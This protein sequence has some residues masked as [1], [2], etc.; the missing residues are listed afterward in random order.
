MRLPGITDRTAIV[1]G[2]GSGKSTFGAWLLS[3]QPWDKQPYVC[4]DFKGEDLLMSIDGII[5]ID[6]REKLPKHPGL[7]ITHPLPRERDEVEDFMW[8]C[9]HR[10]NIGLFFDEG[11]L[12]P[13][14][15]PRYEA[16]RTLCVTGRSKRIPLIV[17]TQQPVR[18][19]RHVFTEATRIVC[20]RLN[21]TEDERR[22]ASYVR[23]LRDEEFAVLPRYYAY[24]YDTQEQQLALLQPVP[25]AD[26]ILATFRERLKPDRSFSWR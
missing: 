2:S 10:E 6:I 25:D 20:F 21:A 23:P 22:V 8:R 4:V 19:P 3:Q 24:Y 11:Y 9:W 5:E 7:Y 17:N 12:V 13:D 14:Q 26:A 15:E 16:F 1:G 18:V